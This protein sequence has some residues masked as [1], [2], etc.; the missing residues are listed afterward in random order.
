ML[1]RVA[2]AAI[3]AAALPRRRSA[4]LGAGWPGRAWWPRF[5]LTITGLAGALAGAFVVSVALRQAPPAAAVDW[6]TRGTAFGEIA[7]D[8]SDE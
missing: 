8:G 3:P 2:A 5:G 7:T 6:Q 1:Q 4:R